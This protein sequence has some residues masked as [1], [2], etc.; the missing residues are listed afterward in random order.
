MIEETIRNFPQQFTF[1]P[2]VKNAEKL[3]PFN[4]L[5]IGGM[6]GSGLIAGILR[7]LKPK[8]DIAAHP[9]YGLPTYLKDADKRLFIASSYSGDTEEVLDFFSQAVARELNVAAITIGGK[10]LKL[11]EENTVP[12]IQIPDT[13]IQPRMS[14]GLM[15]RAVLKLIGDEVLYQ[16][17]G[18]LAGA[19]KSEE[20][21]IRG[22][23]I[24]EKLLNYTPVIYGSRR[25]AA[26]AYN[27]KIKF[28]ETG[29]IPAFYNVLPELNHTEMTGLDVKEGTHTFSEK[30]H[31]I[32]LRDKD[33]HPRIQRRMEV[34]EKL[35]QDRKLRVLSIEVAGATRLEKIARLIILG[36][37]ITYHLALKYGVEPEQVPMVEEF[38][39][40]I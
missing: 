24:T 34:L 9:D 4:S 25:N 10:L 11:A 7:A 28:N 6:G 18:K 14:A 23:E 1:E 39:K 2:E 35:Y 40:L 12:V 16:E 37:W 32:F 17:A 8:M 22:K 13:G 26:I 27:L 19:L 33:D 31:F 38:K 29:K 20:L 15:L 5:V 3:R 30:L 21:E 36:D